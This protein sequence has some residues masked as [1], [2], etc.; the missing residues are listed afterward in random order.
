VP[1]PQRPLLALDDQRPRPGEDEEI[2]LVVLVVVHRERLAG[3]EHP[4]RD[5][6]RLPPVVLVRPRARPEPGDAP[7][8][9]VGQVPDAP[10]RHAGNLDGPPGP[11]RG[12]P[13]PPRPR[14]PLARDL[15]RAQLEQ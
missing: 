4:K 14:G 15:R 3:A 2:L 11:P 1:L 8:A 13:A 7:P 6:D 5:A 10:F 9:Q 12:E